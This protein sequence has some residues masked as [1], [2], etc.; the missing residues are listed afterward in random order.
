MFF[1]HLNINVIAYV[2][3]FFKLVVV[4]AQKTLFER[5]KYPAAAPLL[6]G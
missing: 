4:L 6:N 2:C 3:M 1:K 5:K